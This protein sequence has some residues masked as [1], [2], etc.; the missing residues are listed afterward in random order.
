MDGAFSVYWVIKETKDFPLVIHKHLG[1]PLSLAKQL[2]QPKISAVIGQK[3]REKK[4]STPT[5]PTP[6]INR[7]VHDMFLTSMNLRR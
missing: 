7:A 4:R 6:R 3:E 5:P 2:Q 1:F